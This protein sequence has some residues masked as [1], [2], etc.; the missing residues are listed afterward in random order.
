MVHRFTFKRGRRCDYIRYFIYFLKGIF[1]GD[2]L[3]TLLFILSVNPLSFLFHKIQGY[4]CG[5]HK[6]NNVTHNFFADDLKLYASS[7]NTA[8]KQL[9]L[10]TAFSKDTGMTFG[11]DK[12]AYQQTQKGKLLQC[13]KNLDINQLSIK[14]MKEGDT[15]KYLGIDENT[16]YI[17]PINKEN[18]KGILS[19]N[20][21]DMEF[22]IIIVQ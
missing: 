21:K 8:K 14:A 16:S 1:Q 22:R 17:G 7:I 15:Y 18:Y 11:D 10:V 9:D 3:S 12:C 5:K 2:S 6:N 13:T 20:K 19:L 4:A